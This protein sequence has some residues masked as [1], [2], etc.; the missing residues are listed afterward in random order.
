[1][2]LQSPDKNV[3]ARGGHILDS[4]PFGKPREPLPVPAFLLTQAY[5]FFLAFFLA[6]FFVAFFFEAV[7]LAMMVSMSGLTAV[8]YIH[9][10]LN[11]Q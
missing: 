5:L 11:F 9:P 3:P 10:E 7:F 8:E 1:M 2:S 4:L 6:F